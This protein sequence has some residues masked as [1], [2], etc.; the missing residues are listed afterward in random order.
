MGDR[1]WKLGISDLLYIICGQWNNENNKKVRE[2]E[3]KR[4]HH[5]IHARTKQNKTT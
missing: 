1:I 4:D 5:S 2:Q 3:R